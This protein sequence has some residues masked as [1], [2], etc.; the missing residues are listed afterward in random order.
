[1]PALVQAL[2]ERHP[3]LKRPVVWDDFVL[4]AER[5]PVHV[6]VV[7]LSHEGR[8]RRVGQHALTQL[9][10]RLSRAERIVWGMHERCHF[11]RDDPGVACY[12]G[13]ET[14]RSAGEEFADIFA[15]AV[16]PP[17]RVFVRGLREE[18]F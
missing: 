18:D 11:W 12:F 17:A 4:I 1:M 15:W 8:L 16:T 3:E 2:S 10:D 13:D 6:L 5:E 9:A 14:D 7:R